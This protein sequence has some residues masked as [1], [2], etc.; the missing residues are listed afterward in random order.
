[1]R[2]CDFARAAVSLAGLLALLA[3][4]P[5]AALA[6]CDGLDGPVVTAAREALEAGNVN[7]VLL[8]VQPEGEPEVRAAFDH[9]LAVRKLGSGAKE[10]ADRYFFETLVRVHRA[11]EGASY[12]GLK[13]AGRDLGPAIPAADHAIE[14]GS[15]AQLREL[16]MRS[17]DA[18]L[19]ERF[20]RVTATK[21]FRAGDVDAGR[22]F[23]KA[24]IEFVHYVDG[25]SQAAAGPAAPHE[26]NAPEPAH[27]H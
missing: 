7:L 9:V 19:Q 3:I 25:V 15:A 1:M 26:H 6:H 12:T 18:G 23:V 11:G 17:L 21:D 4:T 20:R 13:P 10:L 27:A 14:H 2:C 5:A 22:R 16:L 24:Y 8:W